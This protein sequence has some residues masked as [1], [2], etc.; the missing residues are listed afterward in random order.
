MLEV[1]VYSPQDPLFRRILARGGEIAAEVGPAVADIVAAVRDGGGAALQE[2][3]TRFDSDQVDLEHLVVTEEELALARRSV[4]DSFLAALTLARVNIRKFHEYQR[5]QGYLH[6]DG[7]GVRLAKR[8]L[9]LARVGVYAPAGT[10]PLFSS[11]LMNVVPAQ[12]A[13]VK[14]I[15]AATPPRRDG[16]VDPHLLATAS[17]LGLDAVYRMGG[18][19]AVA[20]LA[21]GAGPVEAVDKIVGPGNAYVAAAKRLVYGTVG[22]D[23]PAGPSEIVIIADHTA[24]ARFIAADLLSQTE[25]GS[26]Y[27]AGVVL[28]TDRLLAEAVRIEVGRML[29]GLSRAAAIEIA[30]SRFGAIY[31]CRDLAEAVAAANAIAPEH[32]ELMTRTNEAVLGEVENAGAVFLGHWSGE[33]VGD[34]FAGTNHI[35]P[36]GGAARFASSLGV[37]DFVKDI[38]VIEYT[39]ERLRKTG[40]H[41]IHLA[42]TEGLSAH[43]NAIRVRLENLGPPD[44]GRWDNA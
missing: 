2:Y 27:E 9:P 17:L 41:I 19:H 18:A 7:D 6:D 37:A 29:P 25:H 35:L 5:R 38:S 14:K 40:R 15:V 21:Y 30:L 44:N 22:I 36:T 4:S 8:V 26:G 1:R 39:E 23:A 16:T 32:L 12:I 34:Y 31:V 11:L 13:G 43:A 24:N 28:T 10:A 20:A 3:I 33:P 42:E